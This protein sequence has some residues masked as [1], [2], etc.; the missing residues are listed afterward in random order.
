MLTQPYVVL[1]FETT[2]LK[3]HDRV[4]EIAALRVDGPRVTQ[5]QTL[6]HPGMALPPYITELTGITDA[7]LEGAPPT[8]EAIR[9]LMGEILYDQP[10]LIAHNATFDHRF[11]DQ[12]LALAGLPPYGGAHFCTMR[13]ARR[14][15]PKLPSHGLEKLVRY[16]QIPIDQHHRALADVQATHYLLGLLAR[17]AQAT[18]VN[19]TA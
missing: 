2:G 18:G 12:E 8:T 17:E 11:L 1:D 16:L 3:A 5:F 19:L 15:F 9:R 4:I 13:W 6:C 10:L 7:D 14:L